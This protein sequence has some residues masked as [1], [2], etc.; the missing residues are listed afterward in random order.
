MWS[1]DR[2]RPTAGVCFVFADAGHPAVEMLQARG[3]A[4]FEHYVVLANLTAARM[5]E[6]RVRGFIGEAGTRVIGLLGFGD[7]GAKIAAG[8]VDWGVEASRICVVDDR[9][10][11]QVAAGNAGLAV[12]GMDD[13]L[14]RDAALIATPLAVVGRFSEMVRRAEGEGRPVWDNSMAWDGRGEFVGRGVVSV[15]SGADRCVE[16]DGSSIRVADNGLALS[17]GVIADLDV[18]VGGV[19]CRAVR[20]TPSVLARH[21]DG[22]IELKGPEGTRPRG[23]FVGLAGQSNHIDAA[24]G[25]FAARQVLRE[26]FPEAVSELMP[27]EHR[28]ALGATAFEGTVARTC[29]GRSLGSPYMTAMEQTAIGVLARQYCGRGAMGSTIVE[30]GSAL[31]GSG[32]LMAAATRRESGADGPAIV[33]IDPDVATRGAMRAVFEVEGYAS[34]L[35]QVV[36][37][38]DEAIGEVARSHPGGVGMVFIDGLHTAEAA[39]RDFENYAPLVRPGGC[40]MFHDCDVRHTGV[41]RTVARIAASDTRFVLRCM[42]DTLAVFE[43]RM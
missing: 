9:A 14:L 27:S 38:S 42:I 6:R 21:E 8:L 25:I 36:K 18:V 15:T 32:V 5:M 20:T 19:A 3:G 39:G 43:R 35:T 17:L 24:L 2:V 10:E 40:V 26:L 37:T 28:G 22:A 7:Q 11:R 16:C 23:W 31:G 33:S 13:A 4:E 30:I 29:T 41:F 34:R 1:N 12:V